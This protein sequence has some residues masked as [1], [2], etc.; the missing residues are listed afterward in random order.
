MNCTP[1]AKNLAGRKYF[2]SPSTNTHTFA[3]RQKC[4]DLLVGT[5]VRV[6]DAADLV[7]VLFD[8]DSV[9]N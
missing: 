8:D 9:E 5:R 4:Q 6:L 7:G 2:L 3:F 1:K